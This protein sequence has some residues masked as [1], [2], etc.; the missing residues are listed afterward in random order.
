MP[1]PILVL[2]MALDDSHGVGRA[3]DGGPARTV[4]EVFANNP[5]EAFALLRTARSAGPEE[6]ARLWHEDLQ[7]AG[8]IPLVGLDQ[9]QCMVF[10]TPIRFGRPV[11]GNSAGKAIIGSVAITAPSIGT[12]VLGLMDITEPERLGIMARPI[13]A[14]LN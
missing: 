3:P 12:G 8:E 9:A 5:L 10:C 14:N 13:L 6:W 4:V 1:T 7:S 11:F 2:G